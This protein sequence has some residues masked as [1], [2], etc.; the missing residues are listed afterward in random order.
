MPEVAVQLEGLGAISA[1]NTPQ[2]LTSWMQTEK[3]RWEK[4]GRA[5]GIKL[6]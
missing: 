3:A 4:L 2:Q 1:V 5:K 6:E